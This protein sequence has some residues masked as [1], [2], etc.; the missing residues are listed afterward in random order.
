MKAIRR[1]NHLGK[2]EK[3]LQAVQTLGI[4]HEVSLIFGLPEQTLSSFM[5][6][7][8]WCL[9]RKVPVIKA[10]P[11]MLLRGTELE[12]NRE[13]WALVEEAGP[14]PCVIQSNTFSHEDWL[15]MER[16][17]TALKNSEGQHPASVRELA[18]D[19]SHTTPKLERWRPELP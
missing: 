18:D 4:P 12:R 2:A 15:A 6:S 14:M 13:T 1:M 17:S 10:F 11:L 5:A 8:Q 16:L 3:A 9:E 19:G 7:V